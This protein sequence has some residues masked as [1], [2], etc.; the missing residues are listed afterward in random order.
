LDEL[1]ER[2][3]APSALIDAYYVESRIRRWVGCRPSRWDRH[4]FPLYSPTGTRAAFA[5]GRAS[6]AEAELLLE[7]F[8]RTNLGLDDVP[9]VKE[10]LARHADPKQ[11]FEDALRAKIESD[12]AAR[13]AFLAALE[14]EDAAPGSP[15]GEMSAQGGASAE[16]VDEL[17]GQLRPDSEVFDV[18]DTARMIDDGHRLV[19][20]D[21]TRKRALHSACAGVAWLGELDP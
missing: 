3:C 10:T 2:G 9:F 21:W 12:P 8:D 11:A 13:A 6:R 16:V 1:D 19:E 18:F 17:L 4:V 7:L 15:A 14:A 20:L 5:A